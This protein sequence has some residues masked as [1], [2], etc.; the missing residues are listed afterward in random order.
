MGHR[1]TPAKA[2]KAVNA[3]A[4]ANKKRKSSSSTKTA[5]K[6][7]ADDDGRTALSATTAANAAASEATNGTKLAKMTLPRGGGGGELLDQYDKDDKV[8]LKEMVRL[9]VAGVHKPTKV[10]T[11]T[12]TAARDQEG[13]EEDVQDEVGAA[14]VSSTKKAKL[15]D[16]LEEEGLVYVVETKIVKSYNLTTTGLE[17][18]SGGLSDADVTIKAHTNQPASDI[19][20]PLHENDIGQHAMT[21]PNRLPS[22]SR[23]P[24]TAPST[25]AR[26]SSTVSRASRRPWLCS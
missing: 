16:K 22:P 5:A 2:A 12:M 18:L 3:N 11:T 25:L 6:A 20:Q 10:E 26:C 13:G 1:T 8:Y 14:T 19:P 23:P 7:G 17:K 9:R 21:T 15:L 4:K 24:A